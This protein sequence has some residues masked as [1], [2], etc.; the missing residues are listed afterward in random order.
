MKKH[1]FHRLVLTLFGGR[2]FAAGILAMFVLSFNAPWASATLKLGTPFSD[3]MVIQRDQEVTVWGEANPGSDVEIQLG[4]E[5]SFSKADSGGRWKVALK[6]LPVGGPYSAHI[7]SGAEAISLKDILSGD[8]W[9]CAGQSNM[10]LG[11]GEDAEAD[12]MQAQART[13][14]NIRLLPIP[15]SGAESPNYLVAAKWATAD[16]P[17]LEHSTP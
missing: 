9:L 11:V 4:D 8:I 15:K 7:A 14:T 16:S 12:Q 10:Q 5:T 2:L 13:L 6:P 1:G 17:A 3:N